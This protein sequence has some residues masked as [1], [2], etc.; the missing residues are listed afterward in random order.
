VISKPIKNDVSNYG[1]NLK[2]I[3]QQ[4]PITIL[5]MFFAAEFPIRLKLFFPGFKEVLWVWIM[6]SQKVMGSDY[7]KSNCYGFGLWE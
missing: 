5:V 6:G 2:K 3:N 1:I 7:G 4:S